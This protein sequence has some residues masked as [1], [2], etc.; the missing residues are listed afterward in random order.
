M[1]TISVLLVFTVLLTG[2]SNNIPETYKLMEE[3]CKVPLEVSVTIDPAW[4]NKVTITCKEAK[5]ELK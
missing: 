4:G 1:K 5:K 3:G 2:C